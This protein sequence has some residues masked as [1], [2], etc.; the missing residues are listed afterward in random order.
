MLEDVLARANSV[1]LLALTRPER[2]VFALLV[3]RVNCAALCCA[4]LCLGS[5]ENK[6]IQESYPTNNIIVG[7]CRLRWL[8]DGRIYRRCPPKQARSKLSLC[9]KS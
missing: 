5:K 7:N 8:R 4:V 1:C 3:M 2:R 9:Q 6:E